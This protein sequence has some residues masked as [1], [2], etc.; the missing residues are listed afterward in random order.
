[1]AI[2]IKNV[3]EALAEDLGLPC[4]YIKIECFMNEHCSKWCD[5][6]CIAKNVIDSKTE[7]WK[8]Y[9]KTRCLQ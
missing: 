4:D 5:E 1:M 9:L 6:N 8:Q 3:A 7:C 2:V